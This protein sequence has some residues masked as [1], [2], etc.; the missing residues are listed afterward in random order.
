[1]SAAEHALAPLPGIDDDL[2]R[3]TIACLLLDPLEFPAVAE[4]VSAADFEDP[5]AQHL[6]VTLA[7]AREELRAPDGRID[8]VLLARYLAT[9]GELAL[10]GGA[11]GIAEILDLE[12]AAA[13]VRRYAIEIR[14][15]AVK[16]EIN[17]RLADVARQ[18][19][20]AE[21]FAMLSDR[22]SELQE[23]RAGAEAEAL[24]R[25]GMTALELVALCDQPDPVSPLPGFLDPEPS[26]H[27][28]HGVAK[29]GKTN[30]VWNLV[31]AW[32]SGAPPWSGAPSLPRGRA[33]V[34]SAEQGVRKCSRVLRRLA[35]SAGF[36]SIHDWAAGLT[37][38]GRHGAMSDTEKRL[39]VLDAEGISLLRRVLR[40]A[41][42]DGSPYSVVA[43]DSLSRV[44]PPGARIDE[45]NDDALAVLKPLADLAVEM[46]VYVLL[47][48]HSGHAS[49]RR[50]KAIDGVRGASA[51]RDVPQVLI[52]LDKH[53]DPRC[54]VVRVAGNEVPDLFAVF[55]VANRFENEGFINRF[56]LEDDRALDL[57][58]VF[59]EGPL[60]LIEF[61]RRALGWAPDRAPSGGAKAKANAVLESLRDQGVVRKEGAGWALV[62]G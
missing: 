4:I 17:R 60:G 1:M 49:D 37:I 34:L 50:G 7:A 3:L 9:R 38:I 27:V 2:E 11:V 59:A 16:R 6:F 57:E 8:S 43:I 26:L 61:G 31:L 30:F 19:E 39:L 47:I 22:F 28:V 5:R 10:V 58:K 35:S 20:D 41:K 18:P 46:G 54:R 45:S 23:L 42:D 36:G 33:L 56:E 53:E 13:N 55:R 40:K 48:H 24:A 14:K 21:A 32:L 52:V 44:K 51:I 15:A 29:V 25:V 12:P 62:E